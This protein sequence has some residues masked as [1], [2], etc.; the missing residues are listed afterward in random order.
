M[1]VRIARGASE[2]IGQAFFLFTVI[3]AAVSLVVVL[4][5]WLLGV[6]PPT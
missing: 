4:V 3:G 2:T 1:G 6:I 5:L